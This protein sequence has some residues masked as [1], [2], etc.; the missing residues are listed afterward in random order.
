MYMYTY[1][2]TYIYIYI[3]IDTRCGAR[4]AVYAVLGAVPG[5]ANKGTL[6]AFV[7]KKTK[8]YI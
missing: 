3:Y 4:G 7:Y 8:T 2:Y 5:A 1:V 6:Y